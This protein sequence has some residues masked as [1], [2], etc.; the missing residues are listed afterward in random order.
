MMQEYALPDL[1]ELGSFIFTTTRT[2]MLRAIADFP[3]GQAQARMTIDGYD[4]P[5]DLVATLTVSEHEV[6][7]DYTGTSPTSDF[8]INCPKSYTD[9]YTAFGVKCIVAPTIPN[10][11]GSLELI[12]IE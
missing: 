4:R 5:V 1:R 8:G 7:V 3:K 11:A 2:A 10:N 12:R 9:A 6:A